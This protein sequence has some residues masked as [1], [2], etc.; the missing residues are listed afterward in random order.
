M[1]IMVFIV[2]NK[3]FWFYNEFGRTKTNNPKLLYIGYIYFIM[4]FQ[5]L[6]ITFE[7]SSFCSREYSITVALSCHHALRSS[8]HFYTIKIMYFTL[9]HHDRLFYLIYLRMKF[10]HWINT[11][12]LGVCCV[13]NI[14]CS[15]CLNS[16]YD[17]QT[18]SFLQQ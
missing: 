17:G 5:N 16:K 7:L 4:Y 18:S 3:M 8:I 15:D 11:I 1:Y 9:L 2:F 6:K 10:S 13:Y 14:E 12:T